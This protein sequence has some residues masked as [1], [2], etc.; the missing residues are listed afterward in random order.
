MSSFNALIVI[1]ALIVGIA[2]LLWRFLRTRSEV[3]QDE[4]HLGRLLGKEVPAGENPPDENIPGL[5]ERRLRAAGLEVQAAM[6]IGTVILIAALVALAI[7][8][9]APALYWAAPLAGHA[10]NEHLPRFV[11]CGALPFSAPRRHRKLRLQ[12]K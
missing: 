11:I 10:R 7:L 5:I 6:G 2:F 12:A 4:E 8:I 9:V 1:A 3:R